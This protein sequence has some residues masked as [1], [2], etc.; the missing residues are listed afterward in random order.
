MKVCG[1]LWWWQQW[2]D[3]LVPSVLSAETTCQ[4]MSGS[5]ST[6]TSKS[7]F[8]QSSITPGCGCC[9]S[10]P[11]QG[12]TLGLPGE[13]RYVRGNQ[14][15]SFALILGFTACSFPTTEYIERYGTN[16]VW[17]GYRRNHKGGIPPQ[18]TRKTCIVKF[19]LESTFSSMHHICYSQ[20]P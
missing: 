19:L 15:S 1:M 10:L 3:F 18:K 7:L 14:V 2:C 8:L 17:T 9:G 5:L 16:P 20:Q 13:W 6:G 4:N 12:Q 11:L